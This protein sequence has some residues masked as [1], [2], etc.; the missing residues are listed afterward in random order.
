VLGDTRPTDETV[1]GS[2]RREILA[3]D[4]LFWGNKGRR[5]GF[6]FRIAVILRSKSAI[7]LSEK[8]KKSCNKRSTV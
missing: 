1:D 3:T 2:E 6:N 5:P 7:Q 4:S 8:E